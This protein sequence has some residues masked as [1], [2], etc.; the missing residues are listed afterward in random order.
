MAE[1]I[2]HRLV[3]AALE[4]ALP[5]ALERGRYKAVEDFLG[6]CVE[7]YAG[8]PKL[9]FKWLANDSPK[10]IFESLDNSVPKG[11]YPELIAR[12]TQGSMQI[13]KADVFIDIERF[14]RINVLATSPAEVPAA[15]DLLETR[16]NL[17]FLRQCINRIPL[18]EFVDADS[19]AAYLQIQSGSFSLLDRD[20][21]EK[22]LGDGTL[23]EI[24]AE[25]APDLPA[26]A[27]PG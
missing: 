22:K 26:P 16:N 2:L 17:G 8:M 15:A 9:L 23:A 24:V 1:K 18:I 7:A 6:H 11:T 21:Y 12:G 27:A 19:G 13:Y 5:A 4:T 14:Q 10:Y 20:L 3:A 25:L